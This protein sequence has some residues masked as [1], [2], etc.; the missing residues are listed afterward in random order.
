[1][2]AR[3]RIFLCLGFVILVALDAPTTGA[4][5]RWWGVSVGTDYANFSPMPVASLET[6]LWPEDKKFGYQAYLEYAN[7]SCDNTMWTVGAE[8]LWRLHRFYFGGGLALSDERLCDR[9][10]T[11][12]HFSLAFGARI[13]KHLDVQWRHRSHGSD[14][15]ISE[16][17]P[18]AGVN[19]IELRWRTN[20]RE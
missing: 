8:A 11:K 20:W 7:P 16:N 2:Y 17:T 6:G 5:E 18:N 4:A 15:G 19:L 10:G 12:W 3:L 1:M 14:L 9:Q 13:T